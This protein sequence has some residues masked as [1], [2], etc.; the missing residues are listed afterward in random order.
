V[1]EADCIA[2][3]ERPFPLTL[4]MYSVTLVLRDGNRYPKPDGFLS[5]RASLGITFFQG[6]FI[7][8]REIS[9]FSLMKI[10]IPWKNGVPK[11]ALRVQ[12]WFIF[13]PMVF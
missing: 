10:E 5:N 11:L 8:S 12:F 1:A 2:S 6:N 4:F 3:R 13:I 9:S 7:F